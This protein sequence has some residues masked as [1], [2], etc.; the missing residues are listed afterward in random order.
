LPP[1]KNNS[2]FPLPKSLMKLKN[3]H[4]ESLLD[5]IN[6]VQLAIK[7]AGVYPEDHPITIGIIH[8]SYEALTDHLALKSILTCS[9]MGDKLW[10]DDI[11]LESPNTLSVNFT[12]ELGQRAID[13]L[14]F[15]RGLSLPDYLVFIKAMMQK[16]PFQGKATDVAAI[17]KKSN[18][19]T[20]R[21]N[22]VRYG[23]ISG[24]A[25]GGEMDPTPIISIWMG[26]R[27]AR[28]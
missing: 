21:L 5:T 18:V 1:E 15:H 25:K 12:V 13:S 24:A 6:Q 4:K 23:K 16:L 19:S 20:I 10:V 27:S 3:N 14:S 17:L 11:L 22:E 7:S 28:R 8:N 2:E 26:I 9:V